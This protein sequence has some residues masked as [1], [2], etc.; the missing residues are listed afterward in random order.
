MNF[1]FEPVSF[2]LGL[3]LAGLAAAFFFLTQRRAGRDEALLLAQFKAL[4]QDTLSQSQESLLNLATERLKTLQAEAAHEADKR[5]NA[6]SQLVQPIQKGLTE[7]DQRIVALDKTGAGLNQHLTTVVEGQRKLHDETAQLVQALRSPNVRGRWGEMQLQ[8]AL[9]AAGM[10]L[11]ADFDMQVTRTAK[12]GRTIRPD[13]LIRLTEGQELVIDSKAPIDGY[14]DALREGASQAE[15]N[16]ALQRH[17]K[18]LRAHVVELGKRAY[19]QDFNGMDFVVMFVPG[20]GILSAA[21]SRDPQLMEDAANARV[22][23][24]SPLSLL[25][26]LRLIHYGRQQQKLATEAHKIAE[27]GSQLYERLSGFL[28]HFVRIGNQ[29]NTVNK[30]YDEAVGSL[31]SRVLPSAVRMQE[32]G[33]ETKTALPDLKLVDKTTRNIAA[34]E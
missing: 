25:G 17:A 23:L 33:L 31:K 24:A 34:N 11:G 8:R 27:V 3:V 32:L 1:A 14:L 30:T 9:E 18:S 15:Q 10:V 16:D 13:F 2:V 20:E 26:L 6:F 29:I 4:A 5:Q 28:D 7:L 19:W 21:L 22:M 12:D